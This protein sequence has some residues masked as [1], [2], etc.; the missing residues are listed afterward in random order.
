[1]PSSADRIDDNRSLWEE[2]YR[3][4]EAI[5]RY[6]FDAVVTFVFQKL[7]RPVSDR[8]ISVL[9][10]GCGTGNHLRFLIENGYEAYGVDVAP[11]A[12]QLTREMLATVRPDY[13]QERLALMDG[14]RI[15]FP[16]A[17]FDA[18][19][20]R[21]SLG[22]NRQSSIR[23]LIEE[24][25]RVLKPGGR[26]FGI[27]FSKRHPDLRFGELVGDG[28]YGNFTAGVFKGLGTRHFFSVEEI[29]D[30]F[31]SFCID[32]IRLLTEESVMGKGGIVQIMVEVTKPQ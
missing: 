26:Y 21:S 4:G 1:M 3:H 24:M 15:P 18:V 9:D 16:N 20:D 22:Q 32:D 27:N 6:P 14:N 17:T 30:L 25:Q 31:A 8:A 23:A 2:R 29:R 28:D 11:T 13:P 7:R 10:F 19:I 5:L 12:L